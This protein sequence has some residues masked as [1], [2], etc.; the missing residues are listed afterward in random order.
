M[1]ARSMSSTDRTARSNERALDL[2]VLYLPFVQLISIGSIALVAVVG[3]FQVI[4]GDQSLGIVVSFI[5]YLRL[6]LSPL[7]Q[8][9]TL[10]TLYQQGSAALDQSFELLAEKPE[11]I[12]RRGARELSAV[13]GEVEFDAHRLRAMTRAGQVLQ[14]RLVQGGAGHDVA[15]VGS[16]GC[17]KSTLIKLVP[18]FYDPTGAGCSSTGTTSARSTCLARRQIGLV[19]QEAM[20]FTGSVRRTSPS[21]TR[22]RAAEIE[23]AARGV[24]VLDVLEALPDGLETEVGEL[25][26][27]LSAASAS[28]SPSPART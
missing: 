26:S 14:R 12:E 24:G 17:G 11:V 1:G 27:S 16:T 28:S 6:A 8:I 13:R 21:P 4:D 23:E 20:L 18:R 2:I 25:G 22:R 10:F 15:I 19:P 5:G 7:P 9:G 3:G